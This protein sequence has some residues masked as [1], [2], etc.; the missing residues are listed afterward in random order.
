[1]AK[2]KCWIAWVCVAAMLVSTLPLYVISFYNHPYYDDY[3]FSAQVHQTW[4]E[5]GSLG[6]VLRSA[7]ESAQSTRQHW[8]GTYTGTI[9]SNLQPGLFGENLYWI[10]NV[11]L[12]T[13]F[14]LCFAFFFKTVFEILGMDRQER[15]M[16]VSLCL[17][18]M[19]QFMPDVGEAF[20]W[21]NGGV[22][23]TFIYSLLALAAALM[24]RWL[25]SEKQR[26]LPAL[27]L[28]AVALGGGSYGGGL[29][30]LCLCVCLSIWLFV[31]RHPKR[32]WFVLV[33]GV[34]LACFLYS[35]L[36]PGNHARAG[37]IGYRASAAKAIVQSLYQGIALIGGYV[38]LPLA[39]VTLL[40]LPALYRAAEKSP[41]RFN[42]PWLV[43]AG[44]VCLFCTQ[45]TPPLYSIASIGAGRIV[46][47]YF[48]SFIAGWMLYI[49]YLC[50]YI[51]RH[52]P[53]LHLPSAKQMAALALSCLCLFGIGSLGFKR[54][55]DVL[56]GAQNLSGP[57]ALISIAT[58]EAAQYHREMT[59]RERLLNDE[60]Q[61]VVTLNALTATPSVFMDDLL[62]PGAVYDVRPSLCSYYGKEEIKLSWEAEP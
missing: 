28:L 58:G 53:A 40:T 34:F 13:A 62:K 47:T 42:H 3:G 4:K 9:L 37:M 31:R 27:M 29:F 46:N 7:I 10:A 30:A 49:Y 1:M 41:W 55:T 18:L 51:A 39:A 36:A 43:L 23:N 52:L 26:M 57:S 24:V 11:F 16:L 59:E 2:V 33:E 19:I 20:Y 44:M 8:Q 35:V 54:D 60:S 21:F 22:G 6:L 17:M 45:L 14:I 50:G 25:H 32:W 48:M 15:M 56:Y 12:L 38:R 61:P 5:T